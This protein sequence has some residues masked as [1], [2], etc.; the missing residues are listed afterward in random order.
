VHNG[1]L[2]KLYASQNIVRVIN[3]RS[4]RWAGHVPRR[5][6]WEMRTKFQSENPK[7]RDDSEDLRVDLRIILER[8]LRE[9]GGNLRTG[10]IWLSIQTWN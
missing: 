9:L 8:I 1:E 6:R 5:K 2:H 3:S 4:T 7:E 10:F